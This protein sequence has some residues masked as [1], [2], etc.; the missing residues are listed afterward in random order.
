MEISIAKGFDGVNTR[1]KVIPCI[2]YPDGY[3]SSSL[4]N[5]DKPISIGQ[6]HINLSYWAQTGSL[7]LVTVSE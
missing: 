5:G 7:M 4:G 1:W 2:Q 6:Y 3:N